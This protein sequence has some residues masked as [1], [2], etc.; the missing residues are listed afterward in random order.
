MD[1]T[2]DQPVSPGMKKMLKEAIVEA[3]KEVHNEWRLEKI[4]SFST[5]FGVIL[6]LATGAMWV[7]SISDRVRAVE[8]AEV[9]DESLITDQSNVFAKIAVDSTSTNLRLTALE[10]KVNDVIDGI[11]RIEQQQTGEAPK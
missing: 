4:L 10:V 6:G 1:E 8:V 2:E 9:H 5:I 11:R 3:D 7:Q